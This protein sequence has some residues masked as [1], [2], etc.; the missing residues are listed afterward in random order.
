MRE[1]RTYGSARGGRGNPVPYRYRCY[2]DTY[3]G[4]ETSDPCDDAL[5]PLSVQF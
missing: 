1:S 2:A 3:L 4:A 5:I